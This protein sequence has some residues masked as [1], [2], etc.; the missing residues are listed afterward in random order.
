MRGASKDWCGTS[1][2]RPCLDRFEVEYMLRNSA[3]LSKGLQALRAPGCFPHGASVAAMGYFRTGSTLLYNTVRLWAV[4]GAGEGLVAGWMCKDPVQLGIG[5]AGAR[6]EKCTM[7]CKDH[8][9]HNG[10]AEHVSVIFMSRRDP[11]YSVC[12]RKLMDQWCGLPQADRKVKAT[13]EQIYAYKKRC[14]EDPEIEKPE[15]VRQCHE[16]ML[17]QASIYQLRWAQGKAVAHDVLME[18]Y[19]RDP[20]TEVRAVARGMGI[21]EAAA[22]DEELVRFVVAM[23]QELHRNPS[24]DMGLTQMHDV[25]TDRQRALKCG[26]LEAWMRSD[27]ACRAWMDS[28]AS[29]TG[30]AKLKEVQEKAAAENRRKERNR[31]GRR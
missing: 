27:E 16:L 22:E 18:D 19:V 6:Q 12:S 2:K 25:H 26:N 11:F 4:L 21:C 3:K 30:N 23:G 7:V 24:K 29:I 9:W 1:E 28:N 17:M 14:K 8:H 15:A 13:W 20:A 5:V 10:I 31:S